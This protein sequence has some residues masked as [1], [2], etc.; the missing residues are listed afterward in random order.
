MKPTILAIGLL[1][2][3]ALPSIA[4]A[5]SADE[6]LVM[7]RA[8]AEPRGAVTI[9]PSPD[10][11]RVPLT[12]GDSGAN[13]YAANGNVGLEIKTVGCLLTSG[14]VSTNADLCVEGTGPTPGDIINFPAQMDPD[15]KTYFVERGAYQEFLPQ[16]TAQQIEVLCTGTVTIAG[17]P[18]SGSCDP[19]AVINT[20]AWV[21]LALEDPSKRTST[22]PTEQNPYS[23]AS[24]VKLYVSSINCQRA[25]TGAIVDNTNCNNLTKNPAFEIREIPAVLVPEFRTAYIT[26]GDVQSAV[27]TIP[28]DQANAVCPK[29]VR[30][31]GNT[32][33]LS[34]DAPK[35][36]ANYLRTAQNLVDPFNHYPSGGTQYQN[37]SPTSD[38]L[39]MAVYGTNCFD[40]S[41]GSAVSTTATNCTYLAHSPSHY[42]V[43]SLP[44]TYV[45]E[46]TSIYVSRSD[47]EAVLPYGGKAGNVWNASH[48]VATICSPGFAGINIYVGATQSELKSWKLFCGEPESPADYARTVNQA[49][50]PEEF[51][52]SGNNAVRYINSDFSGSSYAFSVKSTKCTNIATG[53]SG[54]AKCD[55]LLE[56]PN[57]YDLLT[58]PAAFVPELREIYVQQADLSSALGTGVAAYYNNSV[59]YKTVSQICD[60]GLPRLKVG[61]YTNRQEWTMLCGPPADPAD[62][63]S[64]PTIMG[65][66]FDLYNPSNTSNRMANSDINA[67]EYKF[68]V[69]TT[70]CRN[71]KT[72]ETLTASRCDYLPGAAKKYDVVSMPATFIPQLREIYVDKAQ[73]MAKFPS[74]TRIDDNNSSGSLVNDVCTGSE[75]YFWVAGES[76][77]MFCGTPDDPAR[78]ALV[79]QY[80]VDPVQQYP[81]GKA[82]EYTKLNNDISSGVFKL[83][84]YGTRCVA[85]DTGTF[86]SAQKCYYLD[87]QMKQYDIVS[88]P[89][90]YDVA[91]KLIKV[92]QADLVAAMPYGAG[93]SYYS[94]NY[95][96]AAQICSA[97]L[98]NLRAGLVATDYWKLVC[99][100]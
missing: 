77:R 33:S 47:L 78:Y 92:T 89:V 99:V 87:N 35:N 15:L 31:E 73:L 52:P 59:Y 97:G 24:S 7:R 53:Q 8:I 26:P 98:P 36:P 3:V 46:L 50:D 40:V 85:K 75:P 76:W 62:F 86:P 63:R 70:D 27:P 94:G 17:A 22:F 66:P 29:T 48:D 18:Y 60:Q 93:A 19:K 67:T 71:I 16:F 43:V 9:K 96:T 64:S 69:N 30:I 68:A 49:L 14:I 45:P 38:T 100:N 79:A 39:K 25:D 65:D 57:I 12:V 1:A 34:C 23:S 61:P 84:V 4:Q 82:S 72:G 37:A 54:G 28:L 81:S 6:V 32:W 90:V 51:Y 56:G 88:L 13:V 83:T 11:K 10:Y 20:Y 5:Q 58:I 44:A 91:N 2:S 21:P 41:S 42:D 55:N 80:L 74:L 95:K